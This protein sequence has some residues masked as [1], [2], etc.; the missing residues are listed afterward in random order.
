MDTFNLW[1]EWLIMDILNN[2][3]ELMVPGEKI[4]FE[5]KR[6]VI[7]VSYLFR[8]IG[9]II[10]SIFLFYLGIDMIALFV[11]GFLVIIAGVISM[12]LAFT[13]VEDALTNFRYI[14]TVRNKM[15]MFVS[16]SFNYKHI[17]SVSYSQS[18]VLNKKFLVAGIAM[19]VGG[20]IGVMNDGYMIPGILLLV[21]SLVFFLS[22]VRGFGEIYIIMGSGEIV[23]FKSG[24]GQTQVAA[25]FSKKLMTILN[26]QK[27]S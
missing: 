20:L 8:G 27:T 9:L 21:F 4:E 17:D 18:L 10:V 19:V 13:T 5:S 1:V 3:R 25:D 16:R 22:S 15:N 23:P 26:R 12:I 11:F 6:N 2:W 14:K 24:K 7:D